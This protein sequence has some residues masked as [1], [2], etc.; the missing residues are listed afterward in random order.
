[1]IDAATSTF[2]EAVAVDLQRQLGLA[3]FVD[4][5]ALEQLSRGHMAIL[6]T[7]R[8]AG[9]AVAIRGAGENILAAYAAL[10]RSVPQPVLESAFL[11]IIDA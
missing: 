11:Q 1:M 9:Q 3:G 10:R 2:L 4:D 5:L 7:I 6:A 8:V